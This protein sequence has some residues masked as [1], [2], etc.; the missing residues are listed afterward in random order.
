MRWRSCRS[1]ECGVTM[2]AR[3]RNIEPP[4][5]STPWGARNQARSTRT[6]KETCRIKASTLSHGPLTQSNSSPVIAPK[7]LPRSAHR[8]S[9][10]PKPDNRSRK[11]RRDA[12]SAW[13]HPTNAHRDALPAQSPMSDIARRNDRPPTQ[14]DA[15]LALFERGKPEL[16]T[17]HDGP[18]QILLPAIAGAHQMVA[19][20]VPAW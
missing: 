5:A 10:A 9:R 14:H 19:P 7:P 1:T 4:C 17:R 18:I 3:S 15:E 13:W 20:D 6:I 12:R 2:G 11:T 8:T 16:F